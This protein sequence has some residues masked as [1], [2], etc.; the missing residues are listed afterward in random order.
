MALVYDNEASPYLSSASSV[1]F[2]YDGDLA[3][4]N[5]VAMSVWVYG[6]KT[7]S[8]EKVYASLTDGTNT[9]TVVLTESGVTQTADWTAW[10]IDIRDFTND[11]PS[12]DMGNIASMTIGI[13]DP[14]SPA[15]GGSGTVYIDNVNMFPVRC[16]NSPFAD[17]TNDCIVNLNDLAVLVSEWLDN[18]NF[19]IL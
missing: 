15:A 2:P 6:D 17:L 3:C 9:A 14:I 18:G 13:G 11:N 1:P 5:G 4:T 7:N 12:L 16:L 8:D 10:N 19:P